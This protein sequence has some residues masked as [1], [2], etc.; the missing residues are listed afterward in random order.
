MVPSI[1]ANR[2]PFRSVVNA[3]WL[4]YL[5][6]SSARPYLTRAE[7]REMSSVVL[8]TAFSAPSTFDEHLLANQSI[9]SRV[10]LAL[11]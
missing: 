6:S 2:L 1:S 7:L 9:Y 8:D 3:A 11:C 4:I 10:A 5:L